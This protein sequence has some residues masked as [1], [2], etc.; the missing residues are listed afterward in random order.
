MVLK[1]QHTG[2]KEALTTHHSSQHLTEVGT[3]FGQIR[4]IR[5]NRRFVV[6]SAGTRTSAQGTL[7]FSAR[8]RHGTASSAPESPVHP[9]ECETLQPQHHDCEA[10]RYKVYITCDAPSAKNF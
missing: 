10:S 6:G 5:G 8:N 3:E 7:F 4:Q 9:T 1:R 2:E